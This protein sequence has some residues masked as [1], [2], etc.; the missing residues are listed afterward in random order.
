M[1]SKRKSCILCIMQPILF[2]GSLSGYYCISS[3]RHHHSKSL[4]E[5]SAYHVSKTKVALT[6]SCIMVTL[7][8]LLNHLWI[9]LNM[10]E[11]SA[12]T[13]VT[14]LNEILCCLGDLSVKAYF[15]LK[16]GDKLQMLLSYQS[17]FNSP[18]K[19]TSGCITAD[20]I[21]YA[22]RLQFLNIYI[23]C[24]LLFVYLVIV[25][26]FSKHTDVMHNMRIVIDLLIF[27]AN[28]VT[29]SQINSELTFIYLLFCKLRSGLIKVLSARSTNPAAIEGF[30]TPI[31][32]VSKLT[33]SDIRQAYRQHCVS[34]SLHRLRH[35]HLIAM[36]D[37]R[38]LNSYFSSSLVNWC[39]FVSVIL[40]INSYIIVASCLNSVET[41]ATTVISA[42][43]RFTVY[44][45]TLAVFFFQVQYIVDVVSIV[46]C[47]L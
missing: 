35:F 2:F 40:M 33:S 37:F 28:M 47:V 11:F 34:R 19:E 25:Y 22:R 10:R 13:F 5:N 32:F 36:K 24:C 12:D 18:S 3:F 6:M 29:T 27:Y 15:L 9:M 44:V 4:S 26:A 8:Y 21:K 17:T 31:S 1:T 7:Y 45:S 42:V 30:L 46:S 38:L 41:S 43:A 16:T 39:S 14:V 23:A 20:D